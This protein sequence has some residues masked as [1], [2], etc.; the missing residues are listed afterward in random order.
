MSGTLKK[1]FQKHVLNY[2]MKHSLLGDWIMF[3]YYFDSGTELNHIKKGQL[4]ANAQK[5]ELSFFDQGTLKSVIYLKGLFIDGYSTNKWIKRK[6]QIT[7]F[8]ETRPEGSITFQY[9]IDK[10]ILKLLKKE[11]SG[12]IQIFAFFERVQKK[13]GNKMMPPQMY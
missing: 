7:L 3:E 13:G 6:N 8:D 10:G 1:I 4:E 2:R 9:A 11:D 12:R 5:W